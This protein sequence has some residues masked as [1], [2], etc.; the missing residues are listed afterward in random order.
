MLLLTQA[1]SRSPFAHP[2]TLPTSH[3]VGACHVGSN[4]F[5]TD[6]IGPGSV[7]T[8]AQSR[9]LTFPVCYID[10]GPS[11]G[12]TLSLSSNNPFRNRA[13]SPNSPSGQPSPLDPPRPVSRNPF[14]D[15]TST[16]TKSSQRSP[17]KMSFASDAMAPRPALTGN[18]A[19]L[20][21][22]HV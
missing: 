15:G 17:D 6:H 21:V 14:L 16:N 10:S 19:D 12:L 11:A 8:N 2:K 13:A 4:R 22:R 9:M 5:Q 3:S 20:F 18:A 1:S 7:I